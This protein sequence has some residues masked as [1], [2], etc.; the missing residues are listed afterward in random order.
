MGA[1]AVVDVAGRVLRRE[2]ALPGAVISGDEAVEVEGHRVGERVVVEAE[3][4]KRTRVPVRGAAGRGE[5]VSAGQQRHSGVPGCSPHAQAL[6]YFALCLQCSPVALLGAAVVLR[7][8]LVAEEALLRERRARLV[9]KA[10]RLTP[11]V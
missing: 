4:Y 10:A 5:R 3:A 11:C 7:G 6:V 9:V 1:G 8:P 2:D